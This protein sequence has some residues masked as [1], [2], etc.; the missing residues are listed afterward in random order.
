MLYILYL[1]MLYIYCANKTLGEIPLMIVNDLE[2]IKTRFMLT[3]A[4]KVIIRNYNAN[5]IKKVFRLWERNIGD[6][7]PID[8]SIFKSI[9]ESNNKMNNHYVAEINNNIIGF[10]ATGLNDISIPKS[11]GSIVVL[12]IDRNKQRQGLGSEL[13]KKAENHLISKGVH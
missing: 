6:T 12:L 7:W 2:D 9:I 5:D 10:I 8:F 11:R 13:L 1:R 3:E 4:H